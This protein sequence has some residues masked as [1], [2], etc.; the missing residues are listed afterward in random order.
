M[1]LIHIIFLLFL[2]HTIKC[3]S[4]S[5]TNFKPICIVDSIYYITDEVFDTPGIDFPIAG[6]FLNKL[7]ETTKI[8]TIRY[9]L[10]FSEGDTLNQNIIDET[11]SALRGVGIFSEIKIT[12]ILKKSEK[13]DNDITHSVVEV[14]T[15]DGWSTQLA[16]SFDVGGDNETYKFSLR[17]INLLGLGTELSLNNDY[18]T[19]NS[20]GMG[21]G[22]S[23]KDPNLF[24][25]RNSLDGLF[26]T[27]QFE[28][29]I[30]LNFLKPFYSD[31]ATESYKISTSYFKGNNFFYTPDPIKTKR[32]SIPATFSGLSGWYAISSG[33]NDLFRTAGSLSFRGSSRDSS[34]SPW[35]P[36]E[37][38][39]QLFGGI[40]STRR[41]FIR[42]P[43]VESFGLSLVQIGGFGQVTLGKIIPINNGLDNGLYIGAGVSQSFY[44]NN[45]YT[46]IGIES[47]TSLSGKKSNMTIARTSL[48][49]IYSFNNYNSVVLNFNTSNVWNWDKYLVQRL[50][51]GKGLR[52]YELY[53]LVGDNKINAS[54]EYRFFPDI[55]FLFFTF[56]T[57]AF[58]DI[59]SVWTQ[60]T[61][62][63]NTK[64]HS[65]AG[66]GLRFTN[67]SSPVGLGVIRLEIPFNFDKDKLGQLIISTEQP[68][69]L[70]GKLDF[71]PPAPFL[72]N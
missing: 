2:V 48:K 46:F 3:Y 39:I 11:E 6:P 32:L 9:R 37:N 33:E 30:N 41:K 22:I 38:S 10:T 65:S 15:R 57:V 19:V 72:V 17:E 68:F 51:N 13:S 20:K 43:N 14:K 16:F 1:R 59:G 47:G 27:N 42:I 4:Q 50:D 58:Y 64:W 18:T 31:K 23:F 56:G 49:T 5:T 34:W 28:N 67:L 29:T 24:G 44:K 63:I 66:L 55:K 12:P 35:Y 70:F 45:F 52:G 71:Q 36:F 53:S 60:G 61:K 26:Y 7:H 25:S 8:K 62:I 21:Y 40:S 54:F 69:D